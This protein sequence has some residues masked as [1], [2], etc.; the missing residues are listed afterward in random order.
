VGIILTIIAVA[1]ET[2]ILR[3]AL[4]LRIHVSADSD[5]PIVQPA[6][7]FCRTL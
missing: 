5:L 2:N 6:I 1:L 4:I 7:N 3:L